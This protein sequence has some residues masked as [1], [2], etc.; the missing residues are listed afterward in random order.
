MKKIFLKIISLLVIFFCIWLICNVNFVNALTT[1]GY[2]GGNLPGGSEGIKKLMLT[3]VSAI[4]AAGTGIAAMILL[5]IGAKYVLGSAD[6]K[7]EIKQY[8]VPFTIGA[9]VFFGATG[10]VQLLQRLAT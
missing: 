5:I 1:E 2:G 10:I 6:G 8:A 7:A 9:L 3:I 4:Q